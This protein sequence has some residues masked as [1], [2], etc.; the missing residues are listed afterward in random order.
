MGFAKVFVRVE[1]VWGFWAHP[2]DLAC[3]RKGPVG[4]AFLRA[5]M[6]LWGSCS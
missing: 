2:I 6:L 3:K 5:V 4:N 1:V